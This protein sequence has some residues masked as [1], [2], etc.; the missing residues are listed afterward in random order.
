MMPN[1]I[2]ADRVERFTNELRLAP[3]DVGSYSLEA[4]ARIPPGVASLTLRVS[5]ASQLS[6]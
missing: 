5:M 4:Y 1:C 2:V 3:R 6:E